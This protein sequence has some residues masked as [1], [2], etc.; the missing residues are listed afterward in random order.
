MV[1]H[2]SDQHKWFI[3][4]RSSRTSKYRDWYIWRDGKGPNQPPNNWVSTFGGSA[5]Q[6]DGK[7]NQYYYHFFYPQ[8]PDL[9]WR[10]PAVKD[11]MFDVTRWW[12]DTRRRRIPPG[13]G[14]HAV[15]R[16]RTCTTIRCCRARTPSAIPTMK[17]EYNDKL[18]E[19]HDVLQGLRKVADQY[20][21][22]LIGETWTDEHRGA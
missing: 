21:A 13:C 3:D 22:V 17:N 7:T 12:Y 5:W 14:R 1:N 10:N 11:A 6:F 20:N 4:S 2:T 8:Q 9:N 15:R 16:S 19:V 18:P